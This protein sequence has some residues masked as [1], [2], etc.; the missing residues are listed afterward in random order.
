MNVLAVSLSLFLSLPAARDALPT[1]ETT[2]ATQNDGTP[3][4]ESKPDAKKDADKKE[5]GGTPDAK[6]D[7]EKKEKL[8]E[9][10][11]IIRLQKL[12]E[13]DTRDLEKVKQELADPRNDY[14]QAED[15]LKQVE[16]ALKQKRAEL[17]KLKQDPKAD[18]AKLDSEIAALEKQRTLGRE[19]VD[20]A[21]KERKILEERSAL[22]TVKI[23]KT[24]R[25]IAL[26]QGAP[27]ALTKEAAPN[28]AQKAAPKTPAKAEPSE[29]EKA[30]PE[31]GPAANAELQ[32]AQ[33]E[34]AQKNAELK[35]AKEKL[36]SIDERILFINKNIDL[37]KRILDNLQDKGKNAAEIQ[38]ALQKELDQK[39]AAK[40]AAADLAPLLQKLADADKLVKATAKD[41]GD[42]DDRLKNLETEVKVLQADKAVTR[43]EIERKTKEAADAEAQVKFLQSP[44]APHN[45]MSWMWTHVPTLII[46]IVAMVLLQ[47]LVRVASRR[48]V[49]WMTRHQFRGE[50]I[51]RENRADTLVGVFRNTAS[52]LII[53][54]GS[55]MILQSLGIPI[56]PLLGGAAAGGLA[57]AFGA[58]NLIKDYLSGFMVLL[59]DQYGI[60]DVVK[61]SGISGQV[62]NITLRMTVLRD[63]EGT[64]HFIPHSAISTVSNMT[65]RWA[66]AF[67]EIRVAYKEDVDQVM[68][69]LLELCKEMRADPEFGRFILED[70]EM[71]GVDQ[72]TDNGIV[73]QFLLR[74]SP[75]KQWP[76]KRELLRRIKA[77]FD[78]LGIE[79]PHKEFAYTAHPAAGNGKPAAAAESMR[80]Q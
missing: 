59:E 10:E 72:F 79:L 26:L 48:I 68:Q 53:V 29:P 11:Q 63:N 5:L 3:K 51:D 47:W 80:G 33:K 76:V 38:A 36:Q 22:L 65:H 20:V 4:Q 64:V 31:S 21:Q 32:K 75:L 50:L 42:N 70:P 37:A 16:T 46:V 52:F 61:I 28:P 77:R 66:R 41:I 40:V 15:A 9:S 30:A 78:E 49:N 8:S 14:Q 43:D 13:A 56:M 58:Q 71:L 55:L 60:N 18:T 12:L 44:L 67:F 34:A 27:P 23:E 2:P 74:T 7:A 73:I 62:E 6:K 35:R 57:V 1:Q 19:R 54:G 69:V 24:Q 45:V 39:R 25:A 17:D